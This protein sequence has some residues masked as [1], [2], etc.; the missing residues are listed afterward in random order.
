MCMELLSIIKHLE[1]NSEE[2][3]NQ[4]LEMGYTEKQIF[5][6]LAD[7][8]NEELMEKNGQLI[9]R[10]QDPLCVYEPEF[11]IKI[12]QWIKSS[13]DIYMSRYKDFDR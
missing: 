1:G 6:V 7:H 9:V 12:K 8:E 11:D 13:I 4:L 3:M 10:V 2:K 5:F